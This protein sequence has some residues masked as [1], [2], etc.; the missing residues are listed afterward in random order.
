MGPNSGVPYDL[1]SIG[2]ALRDS[3]K[4]IRFGDFRVRYEP[5]GSPEMSEDGFERDHGAGGRWRNRRGFLTDIWALLK[6]EWVGCGRQSAA[7]RLRSIE[8]LPGGHRVQTGG[9]LVDDD[10]Q[11]PAAQ[12]EERRRRSAFPTDPT[13]IIKGR[14]RSARARPTTAAGRRTAS[15]SACAGIPTDRRCRAR[16]GLTWIPGTCSGTRRSPARR[17]RRPAARSPGAGRRAA[18][19]LCALRGTRSRRPRRG[20][21]PAGDALR[22]LGGSGRPALRR[23]EVAQVVE[24]MTE[25]HG[26]A[27]STLALGTT[28]PHRADAS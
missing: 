28:F 21:L 18:G 20:R 4:T 12:R 27:S 24:H 11:G 9:R 13:M 8:R 25:N 10:H 5:K 17:A 23:A 3:L 6:Q 15:S 2:T 22:Y 14:P 19:E 1:T 16:R 26:V 7:C